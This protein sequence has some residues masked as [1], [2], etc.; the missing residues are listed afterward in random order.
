VTKL[1]GTVATS[2]VEEAQIRSYKILRTLGERAFTKVQLALVHPNLDR[3]GQKDYQ[4]DAELWWA[5]L[6]LRSPQHEDLEPFTQGEV[7]QRTLLTSKLR[8]MTLGS[9]SCPKHHGHR[10]L[11]SEGEDL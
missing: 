7:L 2:V 5:L 11:P 1:E 8:Q 4:E 6:C 3:D 9:G 10:A